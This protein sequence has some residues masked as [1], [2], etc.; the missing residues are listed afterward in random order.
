MEISE[1]KFKELC[2]YED[3]IGALVGNYY[4]TH[5]LV[6]IETHA[7]EYKEELERYKKLLPSNELYF[8]NCVLKN[9]ILSRRF[10]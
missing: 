7:D 6:Y 4:D 2:S 8:N 10:S 9:G 1:E 5:D 3:A